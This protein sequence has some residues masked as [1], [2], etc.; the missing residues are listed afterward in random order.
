MEH[1]RVETRYVTGLTKVKGGSGDPSPVTAYGTYQGIKACANAVFESPSLRNRKI[2]VQGVGNV[3]YHL[4]KNLTEEGAKVTVSDLDE[5]AS[6][7]VREDFGAAVVDPDEIYDLEVDIFAPCALGGVLNDDTIGRLKCKV[8]AGAANNQ[9]EDEVRHGELLHRM[10][11][12]YAPD[13]VINAGGLMNVYEELEGYNR[14]R[15]FQKVGQLYEALTSI[16]ERSRSEDIPS[17]RA[18]NAVA[19]ERI[20]LLRGVQRTFLPAV[21]R[22]GGQIQR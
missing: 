2:A 9:L 7:R 1:I 10:G 3:G 11:I 18:A 17:Y 13:F 21:G 20:A 19:E 22:P 16:L 8:I 14:E 5:V 15:A 12:C 4:I 6:N